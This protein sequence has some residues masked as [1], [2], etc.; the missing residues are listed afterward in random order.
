MKQSKLSG[1]IHA[2]IGLGM[3][4]GHSIAESSAN[5]LKQ[6]KYLQAIRGASITVTTNNAT[7]AK[8]DG[9]SLPEA[10]DNAN[11]DAQPHPECAPGSGPDEITFD[12]SLSGSV[13]T[14]NATLEIDD[15]LTITGLG[16]QELSIEGNGN[17]VIS[18]NYNTP[19]TVSDVT[20][21]GG[22]ADF[23]AG[24]SSQ[25]N[26]T[27]NRVTLSQ[28]TANDRGGGIGHFF[29]E[30]VLNQVRVID[31]GAIGGGGGVYHGASATMMQMNQSTIMNNLSLNDGAGLLVSGSDAT[32]NQS[33]FSGNRGG[34]GGGITVRYRDL[35]VLDSTIAN[36]YASTGGAVAVTNANSTLLLS[37]TTLSGNTAGGGF[38]AIYMESGTLEMV[39][40]IVANSVS[41]GAECYAA[42]I[43]TNVNNLIEDGS[44]NANAVAPLAVDPMLGPLADN[45]GPTMTLPP[46]PGSPVIDSGDNAQCTASDQL[47]VMR[48]RDGSGDG[49][50][51]CDRGAIEASGPVIF[52]D[53]FEG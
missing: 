29:G 1:A 19:L 33:T 8:G 25:G 52:R 26:L 42:N 14:L 15:S 53:G 5:E 37:N 48:P 23:G 51:T 16:Q 50:A 11:N 27:L 34:D 10:I 21:T 13:I 12:S 28:N 49:M 24:I 36:N 20:L 38:G 39:N 47:G 7:L 44:C 4:S 6:Q 41:P 30:L 32:V 45:G 17:Q 2:A 40:S 35:S 9:C 3:L 43:A 46:L 22:S 18:T 31:N